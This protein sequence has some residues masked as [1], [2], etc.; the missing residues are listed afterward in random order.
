MENPAS[1]PCAWVTFSCTNH[2][3]V[4]NQL[5]LQNLDC[6]CRANS[7]IL[8]SSTP[9]NDE[10]RYCELSITNAMQEV[11][12]GSNG[13]EYCFGASSATPKLAYIHSTIPHSAAST[14]PWVH[15]TTLL[16]AF[17][18]RQI[19]SNR[20][21]PNTFAVFGSERPGTGASA[22]SLH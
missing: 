22:H 6:V 10:R 7:A 5:P 18:S 1:E 8:Q 2:L 11:S 19:I 3:R 4:R 12:M 20:M 9:S 13:D 15:V 14:Q 16:L 21:Q 17:T